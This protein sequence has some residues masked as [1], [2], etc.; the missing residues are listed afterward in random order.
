MAQKFN[1]IKQELDKSLHDPEK[2]WT[3]VFSQ[4]E[5]S[6]GVDRIYIFL[7]TIAI[8]GVWLVFGY[9]AQLVC[10]S[11]GFLYPAYASIHAI[12][13]PCKDDDTKW[14]T[15]WVVFAIFS[16]F[17]YFADVI[18]GWFPL[19]W[20]IKCLFF[21]WLM[22][23]TEFNG[24]LVIYRRIVRPYFLKHHTVI[25]STIQNVKEKASTLLDQKK[26]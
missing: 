3:S 17:E 22:I 8:I 21:V 5:K 26:E 12:E 23:P 13:S 10:N 19:Y 11:V 24:S 9:A 1:E 20:L 14:L 2:P 7:G 18:V 25:D 15:Y 4:V 16:I 6:T